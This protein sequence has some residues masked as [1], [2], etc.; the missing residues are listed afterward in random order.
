[1]KPYPLNHDLP[2][3]VASTVQLSLKGRPSRLVFATLAA[4][5]AIV[6]VD[7]RL[8][9]IWYAILLA[10]EFWG[11]RATYMATLR[12]PLLSRL[13]RRTFY[14]LS[15]GALGSWVYASFGFMSW[16]LGG[17]LGIQ[18]ATLWLCGS[19]M[20]LF[21]YFSRSQQVLLLH[22]AAPFCAIIAAAI[23]DTGLTWHTALMAVITIAFF[24]ATRV[25]ATDRNALLDALEHHAVARAEAE[26]ENGAK[27]QFL[28]TMSH[29]LRTP[30]NAIIGY[31]AIIEEDIES[32]TNPRSADARNVQ[33]AAAHLLGLINEV[34]DLSKLD[35]GRMSL[36]P[37]PTEVNQLLHDV[38]AT[39]TPLA[40]ANDNTLSVFSTVAAID[41][42]LDP[43]R[44]RQCL[45]NLGSNA[46][47]FTEGGQVT[48]VAS[49]DE[50]WLRFEVRDTGPGISA[51]A[52]AQLFTPFSQLDAS[53]TR[54]HEGTGL[55][56]AITR[57]LAQLMAGDVTVQ[58]EVGQGAVFILRIPASKQTQL[59]AA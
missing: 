19:A 9:A 6:S 17:Q 29:E 33:K 51:E 37:E 47:K 38:Q 10:W 24:S 2:P 28:A 11:A 49:E 13:D 40:R 34:L 42:N 59:A 23:V 16:T 20:H 41:R 7:M 44:L 32:G 56:L 26:A 22:L 15:S 53:Y 45:L 48:I 46:C 55:G 5:I 30:L 27:S 31:S 52:Q 54:K 18:L 12:F 4:A 8:V 39:L 58:S 57:K 36:A 14:S 1:M 43:K 21:V 25:F 50:T 35:A 3:E